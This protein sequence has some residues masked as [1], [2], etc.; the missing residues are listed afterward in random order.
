[1]AAPGEAHLARAGPRVLPAGRINGRL[2]RGPRC[3]PL[4]LKLYNN[5]DAIVIVW[6]GGCGVSIC[7]QRY[8]HRQSAGERPGPQA[9]YSELNLMT[10]SKDFFFQDHSFQWKS[11]RIF[12]AFSAN[13]KG[14][15]SILNFLIFTNIPISSENSAGSFRIYMAFSKDFSGFYLNF[16]DF[17]RIPVF[18]GNPAG[19]FTILV[20]YSEDFSGFFFIYLG[21]DLNS[22][23]L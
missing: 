23:E 18:S 5:I 12:A 10:F 2:A 14:F 7:C 9:E 19:S 1:M 6:M 22:V 21:Q 15:F 11:C 20:E 8:R 4:N 3:G 16:C 13:F 17:I